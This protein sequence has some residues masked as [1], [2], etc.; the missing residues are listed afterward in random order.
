MKWGAIFVLFTSFFPWSTRILSFPV[1][2]FL[3]ALEKILN[4]C[5]LEQIIHIFPN[6]LKMLIK[7]KSLK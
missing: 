3:I 2:K 5:I 6:D 1:K 4:T 7:K